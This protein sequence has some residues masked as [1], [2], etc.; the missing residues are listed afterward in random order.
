M[1]ESRYEITDGSRGSFTTARTIAQAHRAAL[2]LLKKGRGRRVIVIRDRMA[3][4]GAISE[5][6]MDDKGNVW[7]W[8][9]REQ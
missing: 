1:I 7:A 2:R 3:R 9:R 6:R 5:W 4:R 8:W